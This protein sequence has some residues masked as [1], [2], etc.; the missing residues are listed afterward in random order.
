MFELWQNPD[1]HQQYVA[2]KMFYQTMDQLRNS[3]KLDLKSNPAGIV[4][5]EIEGCENSGA[6][7]LCQLDTFQKR[8]AQ[9]IEPACHI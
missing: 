6:D 7:K 3:E 4:P 5:I 9:A 8:V 2:V 1:N